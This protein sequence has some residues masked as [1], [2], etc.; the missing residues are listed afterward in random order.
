MDIQQLFKIMLEKNASDLHLR[1]DS[2]PYLRISG[3]LTPA[4]NITPI[5]NSEIKEMIYGLMNPEQKKIF[6]T[7]YECDLSVS[8]ADFGRFRLNVYK[9]KNTVSVCV[10]HIPAEIP[11]FE[12]LNL[13]VIIKK[14]AEN[15]TGLVLVTGQ[16]GCG[17]STTLA[18]MIDHIN[19]TKS[20]N[21]ITIEDPIEFVHKDKKSIISQRELGIDT[22][23]YYDALKHVVRQDPDVILIGEMRDYETV[24]A[25]L[26]AAQ[27]GHLVLSTI[28]TIDTIQTVNRIVEMF[29]PHHQNQIRFQLG[30][31]LKGV[32]SQKLLSSVSSKR[33]IPA[34]EVLVVTPLIKKYI[35][36][37]NLAEISNLLKQG[38]YYGMQTFNQALLKLYKEGKVKLEDALEVAPSPEEL[39]M[40][41]H[42]I[43][44]STEDSTRK[45][46]ERF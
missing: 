36:E 16:T 8:I 37:N 46:I 7:K 5:S 33:M 45:I 22:L 34:V 24:Q 17:K 43:E 10:R 40:S 9:Q 31:C 18:A 14:L 25:A 29:P 35:Q 44:T 32:I 23:S 38:Q 1:S 19:S 41:I 12:S 11:K 21:I 30:D 39:M 6:E 13:P 27:M 2:V 15:D 3:E 42:G 26:T 20:V 28:H 4:D